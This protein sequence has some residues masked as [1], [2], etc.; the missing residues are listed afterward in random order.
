[1]I[2]QVRETETEPLRFDCFENNP[3]DHY[4]PAQRNERIFLDITLVPDPLQWVLDLFKRGK[5]PAM[6]R[7][8]GYPTIAAGL[9]DDLIGAAF[10]QVAAKVQEMMPVLQA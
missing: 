2:G 8:A 5:L 10:L 1:V 4:A 3:H 9:D 7:H 6:L